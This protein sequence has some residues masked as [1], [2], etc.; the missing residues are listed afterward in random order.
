MIFAGCDRQQA[1][2]P[3][4]GTR[5]V[6][7]A[8]VTPASDGTMGGLSVV[9]LQISL[10]LQDPDTRQA[11]AAALKTDTMARGGVDLQD[12]DHS[13]LAHQLLAVGERRGGRTAASLCA[14]IAGRRGLILYMD[15]DRLAAWSGRDTPV[16]AAIENPQAPLPSEFTA[17][18]SPTRT[19]AL[20]SDG[21]LK[22]PILVVLPFRGQA[23]ANRE[24]GKLP[25]ARAI[26]GPDAS[27]PTTPTA[28]VRIP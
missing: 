5:A 11:L 2:G 25:R 9:A 16:V 15:P 22:G 14:E 24:P 21:S 8:R 13:S 7:S 12:C 19:I 1:I 20:P 17:Y 26:Q 6:T 27:Q 3:Q 28:A 23:R 4:T 10:S 18:R